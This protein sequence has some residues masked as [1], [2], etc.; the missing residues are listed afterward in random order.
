[1]RKASAG[2]YADTAG[3]P[4][5]RWFDGSSWTDRTRPRR[6]ADG[7]RSGGSWVLVVAGASVALLVGVP[8]LLALLLSP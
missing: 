3:S 1:M 5:E 8:L 4:S 2:W 7:P 6:S